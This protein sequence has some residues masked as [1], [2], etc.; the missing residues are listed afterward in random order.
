[1]RISAVAPARVGLRGSCGRVPCRRRRACACPAGQPGTAR[2]LR[3]A[4]A[5]AAIA[6]CVPAASAKRHPQVFKSVVTS[7][8]LASWSSTT[9]TCRPSR[10]AGL[11]SAGFAA[12]SSSSTTSHQKVEP[13]PSSLSTPIRPP[14]ISA[15]C[16]QMANPRPVPPNFRAV[17]PSTWVKGENSPPILS[18]GN[19]D[20]RV[21]DAELRR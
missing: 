10:F 8:R 12:G 1:M 4:A 14:I 13:L 2:P 7:S 18:A 9:S 6:A 15:S 16:L 17:E 5:M 20:P 21:A 11:S 19:A 3:A